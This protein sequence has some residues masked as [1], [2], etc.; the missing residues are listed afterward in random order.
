MKMFDQR[1]DRHQHRLV[2]PTIQPLVIDSR[3]V[4][5]YGFQ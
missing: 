4:L 2:A 3:H 1:L 5:Y